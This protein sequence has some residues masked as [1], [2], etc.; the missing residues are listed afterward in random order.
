MI[1]N[2]V[3]AVGYDFVFLYISQSFLCAPGSNADCMARSTPALWL[4]RIVYSQPAVLLGSRIYTK[5]YSRD[6]SGFMGSG[7]LHRLFPG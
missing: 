6:C 1:A 5:T 3:A 2:R 7:V 4:F